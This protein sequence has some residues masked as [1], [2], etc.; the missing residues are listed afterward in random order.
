[1]AARRLLVLALSGVRIVDPELRSMGMTLPGFIERGNVI[2]S[3]PSL[4]LLTIAGAT[5]AHWEVTYAEVNELDADALEPLLDPRPDLVAISSLTARVDDAYSVL[6]WL[7]QNEIPTV[8]GGLHASVQPDEAAL[9]ADAIVVGQGEWVWPQVIADFEAG[10]LH[11][12]YDGLQTTEPL[13]STPLPRWDLLDP[14]RYNRLPLQ[15]TRG[16]P[17]D[18]SFCAA[19]RLISPYKRKSLD[20]VRLELESIL[21]IWPKPF[22][23]LADDNTFINKKWGLELARLFGEFPQVKWFTETDISLADDDR[24]L[25]TLANSGCA[26]VLIG[27]ESVSETSL[28]DADTRQWKRKRRRRY[29]EQIARIQSAGISVNGCFAMGFD[30]DTEETF[31]QTLEFIQESGLSEV[32]LTLLTPFPGTGLFRN[33]ER[34]GRLLRPRFWDHCTLFDVTYQPKHMTAEQLRERFRSL[35]SVVY[36]PEQSKHRANL[37]RRIYRQ[38]GVV[39]A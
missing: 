25:E 12:R 2:A 34:Q 13:D 32:Q 3:M 22:V 39:S 33:L 28:L 18:C 4:R 36:S 17:L 24:L 1:M 8:M 21:K 10:R 14:A 23:E 31:P 11:R 6:G 26:Q 20:R 7:R 27:L 38:R 19:S 29:A 15:T 35:V 9:H 30:A 16:C 37:R 5:P